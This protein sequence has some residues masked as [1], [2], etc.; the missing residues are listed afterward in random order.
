MSEIQEAYAT[1]QEID[2]LLAGIELKIRMIEGVQP[3][4][5]DTLET[6]RDIERLALR[7][8][9]LARRMGL[10]ED[11]DAAVGTVARVI[12][13][14]RMLDISIN[15]MLASNPYTA[16]IGV[17]GLI[18]SAMTMNDMLAGY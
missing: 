7:W 17:A 11:M 9:V 16:A 15:L 1:L 13:A 2:R 18:G 8:L 5:E 3:K 4:L 10:P 12:S 14:L 6:F